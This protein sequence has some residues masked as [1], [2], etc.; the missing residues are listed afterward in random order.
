MAA[1]VS[2]LSPVIITRADAHGAQLRQ[3]LLHAALHHVLQ[4]N[5]AQRA[6]AIG[7][8]QRR[9]ALARNSLGDFDQ[10]RRNRAAVLAH[11]IARRIRVAPLRSCRPSR[12]TPLMR[13]YAENG[14]NWASWLAT[15]RPRK[16]YF[17]FASTTIGAALRRLVGQARKLRGV[18]QFAVGDAVDRE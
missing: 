6:P 13:V 14:M 1:A 10:L 18:G 16:P 15:S 12:S 5:H 11:E 17:A 2:G 3:P 8:R 4:M 9:S 7:H